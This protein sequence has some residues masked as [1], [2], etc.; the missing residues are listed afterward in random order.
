MTLSIA[1][2]QVISRIIDLTDS[3]PDLTAN[4]IEDSEH[5]QL[6]SNLFEDAI[7]EAINDLVDDFAINPDKHFEPKHMSKVVCFNFAFYRI[8]YHK[9]I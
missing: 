2:T 1:Q 4:I 3:L 5:H 8:L 7:L 9:T 6:P